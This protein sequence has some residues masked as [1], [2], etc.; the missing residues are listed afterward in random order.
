MLKLV[1]ADPIGEW[2]VAVFGN[3]TGITDARYHFEG[4]QQMADWVR[5]VGRW[6]A[7]RAEWSLGPAAYAESIGFTLPP[8]EQAVEV[9][10][11]T[12]VCPDCA[13]TV[14]AAARICRF[15]RY[16]FAPAG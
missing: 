2:R 1:F 8:F 6:W 13:E 11:T 16:E 4:F 5:Q 14:Q 3:R 9:L 15:C 7:T 12:K 10:T